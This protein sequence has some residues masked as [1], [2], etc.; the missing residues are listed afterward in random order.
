LTNPRAGQTPPSRTASGRRS[1]LCVKSA[2]SATKRDERSFLAAKSRIWARRLPLGEPRAGLTALTSSKLG[3][4]FTARFSAPSLPA[5]FVES[6]WRRFQRHIPVM[7]PREHAEDRAASPS[8]HAIA[9]TSWNRR[10]TGFSCHFRY[11]TRSRPSYRWIRGA[12]LSAVDGPVF[13]MLR[14]ATHLAPTGR[15]PNHPETISG[16]LPMTH[17][18]PNPGVAEIIELVHTRRPRPLNHSLHEDHV[19]AR[20]NVAGRGPLGGDGDKSNPVADF[21]Q[22]RVWQLRPRL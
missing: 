14:P 3:H 8:S 19:F 6:S 15:V 22:F 4:V 18:C 20:D 5:S 12:S 21:E 7:I 2:P 9:T 16:F 17:D 1:P 13:L 11:S 10:T